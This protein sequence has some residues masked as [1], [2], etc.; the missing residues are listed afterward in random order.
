MCISSMLLQP[1]PLFVCIAPVVQS[2]AALLLLLL[3]HF[4]DIQQCWLDSN[5]AGRKVA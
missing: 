4:T 3:M 5:A 2:I 1:V